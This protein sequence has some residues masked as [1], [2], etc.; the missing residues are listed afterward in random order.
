MEQSPWAQDPPVAAFDLIQNTQD[1]LAQA[2]WDRLTVKT[3]DTQ[4]TLVIL[5]T[6][7]SEDAGAGIGESEGAAAVDDYEYG[8]GE[9]DNSSEAADY[10]GGTGFLVDSENPDVSKDV[11]E[12]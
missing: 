9:A 1:S 5:V 7:Y 4:K 11:D 6:D 10:S 12:L 2:E 8:A 3:L